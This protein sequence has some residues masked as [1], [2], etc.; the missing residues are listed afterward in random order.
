M[1]KTAGAL[2]LACALLATGAAQAEQKPVEPIAPA[3]GINK[4]KAELGK[5]LF[6]ILV[7]LSQVLF[8]VTPVII[9]AGAAQI[10]CKPPL[11]ITGSRDLL[12]HPLS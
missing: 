12:M 5:K 11:V 9:S 1:K 8:L 6:L 3:T 2:F 4:E 7:S 10:T